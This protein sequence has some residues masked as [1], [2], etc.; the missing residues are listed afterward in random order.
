MPAPM[1]MML[2]TGKPVR[3]VRTTPNVFGMSMISNANSGRSG[4]TSCGSS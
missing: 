3:T 2:Y 1:G 4:C